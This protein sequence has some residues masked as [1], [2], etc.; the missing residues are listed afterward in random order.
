MP[1]ERRYDAAAIAQGVR[2]DKRGF[3]DVPAFVTRTG[4]LSYRRADGT[5]VRELRHPDEVFRADSLATLRGAP[6]TVEHPGGG[7][8]WVTPEN[9]D[10]HEVG[11]VAEGTP[12]QN[13]YVDALMSVRRADTIGRINRKELVECSAAYDCD[14]VAESGTFEG[15]AYDQRQTNITYNHVA[16]LPAG[17]GRAGRDV[18]MR[19]DSADAVL[20]DEE[21][22]PPV[23]VPAKEETMGTR[24]LR[25]DGVEYELP[26]TAASVF[27]KVVT[28]RD[29]HKKRA[30]SAEAE[31]DV[32]KGDLAKANDP[33]RIGELVGVRVTLERQAAKVLG[34]EQRF[35]GKSDREVREEVLRKISP[36][37]KCESRTDD[38][39]SA[40]FDYA[41]SNSKGTNH[42]LKVVRGA[43]DATEQQPLDD[44]DKFKRADGTEGDLDAQLDD[45]EKRRVNAWKGGK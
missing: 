42:G 13:K 26:E 25:V 11:V 30:D 36:D 9:A 7:L 31:R 8:E 16:L 5:L 2:T 3:V 23:R 22:V 24:K 33:K 19:A 15:Q 39:V 14:V 35:D 41:V 34:A 28:E 44:K 20:V 1:T 18:R 29:S 4:V 43:I 10:K 40:A 21:P 12:A 38:A 45:L 37:F 27:E 6:V 17:K 32:I